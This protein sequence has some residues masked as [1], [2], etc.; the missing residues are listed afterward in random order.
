MSKNLFF[1]KIIHV[2]NDGYQ[3]SFLLL[4]PF[5]AKDLNISLAQIGN[6]GSLFYLFETIFA[7]PAGYLGEKING[8]KILMVAMLLYALS[9]FAL[10]FAPSFAIL[11][12][13]FTLAGI[14]FALFHPIAFALVAKLTNKNNRG[15]EMGDFMAIGELGRI[16]LS[17]ALTFLAVKIGWRSTSLSYSFAIFVLFLLL[18]IFFNKKNKQVEIT[19]ESIGKVKIIHLLQNGKFMLA[20]LTAFFDVAASSSLFLFL[21]FL[22][23]KKGIDPLVLGAFTAAYFAGNFLGKTVL[24]R[25]VDKLGSA[26]TF[27][28]A[29][30]LMAVFIVL[31]TGTSSTILIII[32]SI[33]LGALTKGTVP[34]RITMAME[35]VEHHGRYEKAAALSGLIASLGNV[36][37]PS[38]YGKTAGAYGI[39]YAFYLSAI[40]AILA[41]F[42]AVAFR[43]VRTKH[44]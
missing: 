44:I 27:I 7:L 12:V 15:R 35:S 38:L 26:K 24:G 10:T 42:P 22:L 16:G 1:L 36:I 33:I 32:F 21:P 34:A 4:L 2:F 20:C 17:T 23:I 8:K 41:I 25:I 6:L 29:E 40:F 30:I 28:I 37:A 9:F 19:E 14:G 43:F 11:I 5:I 31:L 18:L 13:F 39:V 3:A